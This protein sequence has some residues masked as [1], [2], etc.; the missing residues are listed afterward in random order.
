M[1]AI[2]SYSQRFASLKTV[3]LNPLADAVDGIR[4]QI[5]DRKNLI[6]A[7][8]T[9]VRDDDQRME[10]EEALYAD[11][12]PDMGALDAVQRSLRFAQTPREAF[13][14]LINF[15]KVAT[16]RNTTQEVLQK[17]ASAVQIAKSLYAEAF[18]AVAVNGVKRPDST[19]FLYVS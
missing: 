7:E 3:Y 5:S 9:R 13:V 2:P 6:L 15:G 1:A 14:A 11:L 10:Y 18:G 17:H 12:N 16:Q 8:L 19:S 4:D